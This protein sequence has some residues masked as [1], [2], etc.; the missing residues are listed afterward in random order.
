MAESAGRLTGAPVLAPLAAQV[1]IFFLYYPKRLSQVLFVDAPWAFKPGWEMIK[2]VRLRE[3]LAPAP[4]PAAPPAQMPACVAR[5]PGFQ[6]RR[7]Q[8]T[9]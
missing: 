9:A 1:D 8:A 5:L 2:P 6:M 7:G 4:A 3:A